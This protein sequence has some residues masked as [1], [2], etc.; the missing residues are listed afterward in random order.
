LVI[1]SSGVSNFE[2][3]VGA[4][5]FVGGLFS[6]ADLTMAAFSAAFGQIGA[7]FVSLGILLFALS[8]LLGWSYYGQQSLGYLTKNNKTWDWIYKFIFT[9]LV[10][11]GATGGLTLI[12]DIADTLNGLMA[13]PNL[14]GV[15]LLC[16]VIFDLTKEYLAR[17]K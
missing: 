2:A 4:K 16:K 9:C 6:G 3:G 15:L 14:I 7:V 12:W 11:V 17:N 8:T 1:L 10:I 13:I 5:D